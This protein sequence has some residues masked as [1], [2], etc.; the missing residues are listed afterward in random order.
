MKNE[1]FGIMISR[2][3]NGKA[4][5]LG[6]IWVR[7]SPASLPF[8][9]DSKPGLQLRIQRYGYEYNTSLGEALSLYNYKS[10]AHWLNVQSSCSLITCFERT[11]CKS[12]IFCNN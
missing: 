2:Q 1:I 8:L 9:K 12:L 4:W 3:G 11:M 10:R 5:T 6:W 7:P